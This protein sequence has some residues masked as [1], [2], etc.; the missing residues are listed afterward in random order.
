MPRLENTTS[1]S[2]MDLLLIGGLHPYGEK[3]NKKVDTHSVLMLQEKY[4]RQYDDLYEV[5]FKDC[6]K[7]GSLYCEASQP[8]E[9]A[10][11]CDVKERSQ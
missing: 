3:W 11:A 2:V 4:L 1:S 10:N 5:S 8:S 7:T 6:S 9:C